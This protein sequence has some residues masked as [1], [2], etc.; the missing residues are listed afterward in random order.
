MSVVLYNYRLTAS[1][2]AERRLT[3]TTLDDDLQSGATWFLMDASLP[4]NQ[5]PRG[6]IDIGSSRSA[7]TILSSSRLGENLEWGL[8]SLM[9]IVYRSED[10]A[11]LVVVPAG[12]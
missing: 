7:A 9:N 11:R 3:R 1:S 4:T 6:K 12:R 10:G 2:P 8:V 5:T